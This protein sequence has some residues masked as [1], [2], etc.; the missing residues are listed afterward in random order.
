MTVSNS[1]NIPADHND[2]DIIQNNLQTILG[3]G[4]NGYG[5]ISINSRPVAPRELIE[6]N[7]WNNIVDDI[8]TINLHILNT[9][10]GI[11]YVTTQTVLTAAYYNSLETRINYLMDNSRRYT[12]HPS[13]FLVD[14]RAG[15]TTWVSGGDSTRTLAWGANETTQITHKVVTSFR[16]TLSARYYFNDGAYLTWKPYYIN[17]TST[18]VNDLDAEWVNFIDY[19]NVPGREYTYGRYEY[20]NYDST[21]TNWSSGTLRISL[22]ADRSTERDRIDF[23]INYSNI[24]TDDLIINPNVG[25]YAIVL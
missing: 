4:E 22:V 14:P 5:Y 2:F 9:T 23:T 20:N 25:I 1:S 8:D 24:S 12:C 3:L 11:A 16:T 7:R 6:R 13:Q 10:S 15:S 19:L 18:F 21:T 17:N